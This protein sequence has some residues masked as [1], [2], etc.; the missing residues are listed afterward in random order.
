[1]WSLIGFILVGV[2]AA[3]CVIAC[4]VQLEKFISGENNKND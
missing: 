2:I 4:A 3:V 1:M